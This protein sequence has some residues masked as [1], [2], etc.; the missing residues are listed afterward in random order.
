MIEKVI[1]DYLNEHIGRPVWMERPKGEDL[2]EEYVL[3]DKTGSS[4]KDHI[5]TVIIALQSYAAS[6]IN[7]SALNE[8]VK[9]TMDNLIELDEIGSSKLNSDYNFTDTQKKNYR[10]QA[11]YEITHHK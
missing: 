11:V 7:A 2:P 4:C 6:M 10:Y 5:H 8:I 3:M 1:L 9:S